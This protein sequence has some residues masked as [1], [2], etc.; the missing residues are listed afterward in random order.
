V[1]DA[2]QSD[3]NL[4]RRQL[5]LIYSLVAV[6]TCCLGGGGGGSGVCVCV[7]VCACVCVCV[8]VCV[9]VY[10]CVCVCVCV[11]VVR[12]GVCGACGG[13][14]YL[15]CFTN[16]MNFS[17]ESPDSLLSILCAPRRRK[18]VVRLHLLQGP[19]VSEQDVK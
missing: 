19:L 13:G 8:R 2:L 5:A 17:N 4:K 1:S 3:G 9:R 11:C 7:C 15:T 6:V 18:K 12:V 10:V 16:L 14:Y